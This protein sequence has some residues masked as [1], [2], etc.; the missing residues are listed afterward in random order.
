MVRLLSWNVT[1]LNDHEKGVLLKSVLREWYCDLICFQETKLEDVELS[2]I[3]SILGNQHVGFAVLKAIDS[4]GGV[5]VLWNT[6]TFQLVFS[7]N[8]DFSITCFFQ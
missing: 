1:G 8:G 4:A 6:N 5:L 3:R 7:S 2:D